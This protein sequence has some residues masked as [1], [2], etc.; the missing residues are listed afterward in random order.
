MQK[1][2]KEAESL[3]RE[4]E[5]RARDYE[6]DI[7]KLKKENAELRKASGGGAG[8]ESGEKKKRKHM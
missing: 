2:L 3:R 7:K 8:Q 6:D 5:K 1:E 4:A